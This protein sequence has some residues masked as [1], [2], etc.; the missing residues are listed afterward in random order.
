MAA[1]FRAGNYFALRDL[2][3]ELGPNSIIQALKEKLEK[4]KTLSKMNQ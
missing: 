2:P 3:D 4:S 1:C